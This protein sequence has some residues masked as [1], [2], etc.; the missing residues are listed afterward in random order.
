L[1][2]AALIAHLERKQRMA[3]VLCP[4]LCVERCGILG[5]RRGDFAHF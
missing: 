5:D 3:G 2:I 4:F 1:G